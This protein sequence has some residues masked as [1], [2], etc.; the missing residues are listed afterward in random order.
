LRKRP[1]SFGA[2]QQTLNFGQQVGADARQLLER[3][4]RAAQIVDRLVDRAEAAAAQRLDDVEAL[5][6]SA[7]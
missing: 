1:Q 3:D 5:V 4:T 6:R 2:R 7:A